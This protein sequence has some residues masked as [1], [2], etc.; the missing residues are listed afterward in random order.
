MQE[1]DTCCSEGREK[2]WPECT[3]EEK[4][5]RARLQIKKQEME[6]RQLRQAIAELGIRFKNHR[7]S[8]D[9]I[10]FKDIEDLSMFRT[11]GGPTIGGIQHEMEKK[12]EFYF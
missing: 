1:G 5:E 8:S 4:I 9:E 2:W 12:G 11:I 7:H 6:I 3:A 10:L